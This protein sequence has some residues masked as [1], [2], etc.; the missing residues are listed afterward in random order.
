M[1][2]TDT[3]EST[4][5]VLARIDRALDLIDPK[6]RRRDTAET[7][8]QNLEQAVA[9]SGRVQ[10]LVAQLAAEA[11]HHQAAVKT[12]GIS[13][14]SYLSSRRQVTPQEA[15]RLVHTGLEVA[16]HPDVERA[17]LAGVVQPAQAAAIASALDRLPDDVDAGQ[18]GEAAHLLIG[19]AETTDATGLKALSRQVVAMV[20]PGQARDLEE[21][22][23]ARL[24]Q[25]AWKD[26]Y[27]AFKDDGEGSLRF[28]GS[29]PV[30]EGLEVRRLIDAYADQLNREL[31]FT[32]GRGHLVSRA[33]GRADGLVALARDSQRQER[34]PAHGGDRPRLTVVIGY[35]DLIDDL[36]AVRLP[37]T[38]ELVDP[39]TARRLACQADLL[40]VVLGGP[41]QVLD[42]GREHRFVTPGLRRALELRDGGCVFPNCHMPAAKCEAHHITPWWKGGITC[43]DNLVLACPH[44][45][46]ILEPSHNPAADRWTVSL[47]PDGVPEVRPPRHARLPDGPMIHQRFHARHHQLGPPGGAPPRQEP[48]PGLGTLQPALWAA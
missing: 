9:V 37:E 19:R 31:G 29:L 5:Q 30:V 1:N 44:H 36:A 18:L 12:A 40:P 32:P 7:R 4:G 16:K 21:S 35:R 43:L 25:Q 22:R 24:R 38:G 45:H 20:C 39:E 14:T 48:E 15:G 2:T 27:L 6:S 17:A 28:S 34:A 11:E 46:G 8:L 13:V 42:V 10:A 3:V 47:N 26:R 41:S 33:Q 23:A